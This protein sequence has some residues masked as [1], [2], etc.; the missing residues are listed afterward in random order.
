MIE[1]DNILKYCLAL[2]MAS[3]AFLLFWNPRHWWAGTIP[4]AAV[5]LYIGIRALWEII[6][7]LI[8]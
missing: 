8:K 1:L 2:S 6:R 3:T 7:F 4:I 5:L